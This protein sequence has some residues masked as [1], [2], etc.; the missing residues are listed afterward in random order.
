MNEFPS[1][2]CL[3][4]GGGYTWRMYISI[5][6]SKQV[7]VRNGM[8]RCFS[9]ASSFCYSSPVVFLLHSHLYIDLSFN[10]F[11]LSIRD[12]ELLS[13]KL[14]E[15]V[16]DWQWREITIIITIFL[17][18]FLAMELKPKLVRESLM[19]WSFKTYPLH[20]EILIEKKLEKLKLETWTFV[21]R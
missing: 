20:Q 15:R 3:G 12:K 8:C 1:F 16:S 10:Q 11:P 7:T 2:L 19:P 4:G 13:E 9:S 6:D 14:K 21:W 5:S 18:F 17:S